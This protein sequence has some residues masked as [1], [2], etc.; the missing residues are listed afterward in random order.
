MTNVKKNILIVLAIVVGLCISFFI[1]YADGRH[2]EYEHGDATEQVIELR[3][4]LDKQ[5]KLAEQ[6]EQQINQLSKQLG[7]VNDGID[8]SIRLTERAGQLAES[9][10]TTVQDIG[11]TSGDIIAIFGKLQENNKRIRVA[12]DEL[13]NT[14]RKL[15]SKLRELQ[16]S[17]SVE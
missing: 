1:G 13:Q 16:S 17:S 8:E 14:N 5:L 12:V 11:N 3:E 7:G 9:I 4:Q 10:G 15:E 2:V 6:Q